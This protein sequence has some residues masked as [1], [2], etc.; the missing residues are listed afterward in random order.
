MIWFTSDTHFGHTNIIRY[1]NRPFTDIDEMNNTIIRNWNSVVKH[2]DIIYHLGDFSLE[3]GLEK[4]NDIDKY[5]KRLNGNIC[6]IHGNHDKSIK[7]STKITQLGTRYDLKLKEKPYLII[8]S[9]YAMRVWNRCHYGTWHLY[10]HSHGML[11][12]HLLSMDV[13]VDC[14]NFTPISLTEIKTIMEA[15]IKDIDSIGRPT[16]T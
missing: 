16:E 3:K 12:D 13:G 8:L 5:T 6:L 9:H 14:N 1:C 10:G 2:G 11:S 15:K 7:K 4:G